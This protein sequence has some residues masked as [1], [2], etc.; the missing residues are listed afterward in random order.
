MKLLQDKK[1]LG[2]G[3]LK[4]LVVGIVLLVVL[5]TVYS[6]YSSNFTGVTGTIMGFLTVG[7]AIGLFVKSFK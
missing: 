7:A 2:I 6:T 5:V 1:G 3:S 4:A